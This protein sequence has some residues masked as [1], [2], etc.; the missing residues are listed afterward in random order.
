MNGKP[1]DDP[2]LDIVHHGLLV[3]SPEV[4]G[5]VR[6]LAELMDFRRLQ[7]LLQ[8]LAGLSTAAL[9]A[10]LHEIARTLK[11]EGRARGWEVE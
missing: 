5:L 8:S 3:Y 10:K 1:G 6:E 7:D 4:D 9:G 2:A 11:T